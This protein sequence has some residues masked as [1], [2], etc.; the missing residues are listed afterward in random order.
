[1]SANSTSYQLA[2]CMIL[3]RAESDGTKH[4]EKKPRYMGAHNVQPATYLI[5]SLRAKFG[6]ILEQNKVVAFQP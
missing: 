1:M 3:P 4:D 6:V 5:K 2:S